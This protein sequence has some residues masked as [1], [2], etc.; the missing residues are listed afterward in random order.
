MIGIISSQ[1]GHRQN[2]AGIYIHDHTEGTVLHIV[3]VYGC[4]HLLF[5][6][7]LHRNIQGQH[8]AAGII[9]NDKVFIGKGHIH[10][11]IALGGDHFAGACL[12]KAVV[13]CLD[14]LASGIGCVGKADHL[15]GKGFV[16]I[17]PLGLRFQVDALDLIFIDK[18]SDLIRNGR[19]HLGFQ[20]LVPLPQISGLL[21]NPFRIPLQDFSQGTADQRNIRFGLFQFLGIQIHR[22]HSLRYRQYIHI[23][24]QDLTPVGTDSGGTALVAQGKVTVIGMISNHQRIQL[25]HDRHKCQDAQ[26]ESCQGNSSPM[27]AVSPDSGIRILMF[28]HPIP[29]FP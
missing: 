17:I 28:C 23:P 5:Q 13:G 9:G 27:A 2:L 18:D 7:G 24:V 29:S 3:A 26:D 6:T 4:L 19:L 22:F 1:G 10:L 8:H 15:T 11:V 14:P 20:P 16:R 21:G 25:Q 12:Q